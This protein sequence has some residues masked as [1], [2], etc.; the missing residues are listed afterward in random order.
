MQKMSKKFHIGDVL[1]V[2]GV[3]LISPN[4]FSGVSDLIEHM[5][6]KSLT[7]YGCVLTRDKCRL[8]LINQFPQLLNYTD[9]YVDE[10]NWTDHLKRMAEEHGEYLEVNSFDILSKNIK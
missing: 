1:S 10:E 8:E 7:A 4:G 9:D 2:V 3:K 5:T 6:G